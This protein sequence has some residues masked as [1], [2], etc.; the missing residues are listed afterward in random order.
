[1]LVT[2]QLESDTRRINAINHKNVSSLVYKMR[3][4]ESDAYPV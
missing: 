4:T 1:M 2:I 3:N